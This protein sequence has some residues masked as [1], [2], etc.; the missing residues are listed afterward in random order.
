[1]TISNGSTAS[2]SDFVS[3]SAGAADSGKVP[4]LNSSGRL[5]KTFLPVALT[6]IPKPVGSPVIVTGSTDTVVT[7]TIAWVGL[8][9]IPYAIVANKITIR[10]DTVNVAGT[11]DLSL[12]SEDGQTQIFSVTT[13]T[14]STTDALVSTALSAVS[15]ASGQY[16]FMVNP[17]GTAS[18]NFSFWG[19]DNIGL[20]SNTQ[21]IETDVSSKPVLQGKLTITA[22]T[23][24]ATLTPSSITEGTRTIIPFRLDN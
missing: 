6:L 21:S 8:V 9:D 22:G 2:A 10:N 11:L 13:A 20:F 4:K 23:P 5:D 24:P 19:T 14:I 16:Y 15:I 3:T 12:Y 18:I 1:M 7:N 17:N